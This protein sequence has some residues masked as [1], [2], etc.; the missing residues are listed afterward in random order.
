MRST[1]FTKV[2]GPVLLYQRKDDAEGVF[3]CSVCRKEFADKELELVMQQ[4][5]RH[6]CK[7]K[8]KGGSPAKRPAK[9]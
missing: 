4:F 3:V 2:R 5:Q 1:G 6:K 8:L 9:P 7:P